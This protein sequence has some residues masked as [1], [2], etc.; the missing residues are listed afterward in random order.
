MKHT[1]IKTARVTLLT[2]L[3]LSNL[4]WK[5]IPNDETNPPLLTVKGFTFADFNRNGKLDVWE[6]TRL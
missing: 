2:S 1:I 6:D 3:V 5:T 4:S